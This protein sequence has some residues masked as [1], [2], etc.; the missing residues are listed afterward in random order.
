MWL[1]EYKETIGCV[2]CGYAVHFSAL[3]L[4]HQGKKTAE[5]SNIRSSKER[6]LKEIKSGDCVVRCA[7]C[8]SV[9]T[10][11]NKNG[12]EYIPGM[13]QNRNLIPSIKF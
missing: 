5:I 3:Q 7:N 8:H 9:R 2:D 1:A 12:I 4:D 11:A 10:W 6:L 13:A